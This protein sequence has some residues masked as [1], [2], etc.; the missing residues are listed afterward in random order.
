MELKHL[1]LNPEM[2]LM[3]IRAVCVTILECTGL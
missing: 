1:M 2:I 3:S